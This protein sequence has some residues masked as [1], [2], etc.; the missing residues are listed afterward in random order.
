MGNP[1]E[2]QGDTGSCV[3]H[4]ATSAF[5]I[6]TKTA[7]LSRLMA[8]YNARALEG[9]VMSDDGC[10]IRD[11]M[12]AFKSTGCCVE[13]LWPF[14]PQ[15][16]TVKPTAPAYA[17]AKNV[18][19]LVASYERI[20]TLTQVKTALA[21]GLPVTFGF[22]VPQYFMENY[23]ATTGWVRLPKKTDRVVGGHAVLAVGYD[24]RWA[25]IIP[26]SPAP[27][28]WVKNSWGPTWGQ[29]GYFRMDER[30]FSDPRRLVD[31]MWVIHPK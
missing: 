3:G 9:T 2:D 5:E 23:V 26:T 31:D 29:S 10:Y 24:S 21:A 1:V 20:T 30:W 8:Y 7:Q 14:N 11:A 17:D 15:N 4:A 28:V 12:K 6:V 22:V 25:S 18:L 27:F 13:N 19:P 16:V